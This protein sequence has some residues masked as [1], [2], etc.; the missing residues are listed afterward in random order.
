MG[1]GLND[2]EFEYLVG[3]GNSL[4]HRVQTGT[5]AHPLSYKMGTRGSFSGDKAAGS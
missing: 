2:Q 4:H 3:A 5:G 1:Y